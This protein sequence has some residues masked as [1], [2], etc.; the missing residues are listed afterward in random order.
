M[1]CV[2]FIEI[3]G[4]IEFGMINRVFYKLCTKRYNIDS[5]ICTYINMCRYV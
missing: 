2:R 3:F 1:S 5:Y 4:I